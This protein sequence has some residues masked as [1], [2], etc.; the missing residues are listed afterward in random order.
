MHFRRFACFLLGV[1]LAGSCFMAVVA[2]QNFRSVD[3][4]LDLPAPV[5]AQEIKVMGRSL[6]RMFLRYQVSEQN[7]WY[8]ETWESL[9][10]GLGLIFFLLLLFGSTE[11]KFSLTLA[12]LML[13][14]VV[15]QRAFLTPTM[16]FFGRAID[17]VPETTPS[18]ERT[19]FWVLHT[20]YTGLELA[21]CGLGLILTGKLLLRTRRQSAHTGQDVHGVD[22]ADHRHVNR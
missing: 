20:A 2:T 15:C 16:T 4:L 14:M 10:I 11:S 1:W 8:F 5:A 19:R 12:L 9:Q 3:R 6:A 17:F 18:T 21:K 13:L 22:K 7:R